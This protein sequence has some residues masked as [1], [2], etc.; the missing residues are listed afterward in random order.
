M[1]T[2]QRHFVDVWNPSYASNAMEAHLAVLLSADQEY[3]WWGKVR[4]SNRQQ[5]LRHLAAALEIGA[6]LEADQ[7][8]EGHLY[9]TD[10]RSLYVAHIDT[11]T[12]GE[13]VPADPATVPAYYAH[14]RLNCDFWYKLLDIRRLVADDTIAVIAELKQLRNPEYHN[15]PVS[16]YG[17]WWIS[18]SSW[19]GLTA[20]GSSTP[21][22]AIR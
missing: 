9:L 5:P 22:C 10:Y 6:E 16:L 15:R 18:R 12:P 21:R 3:V 1:T 19:S 4:S 13:E 2:P 7:D 11:I 20:G 17:G 14:N 8:R